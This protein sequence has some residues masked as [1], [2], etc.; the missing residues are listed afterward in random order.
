MAVLCLHCYMWAFSSCCRRGLLF[1]LQCAASHCGVFSCGAPALG[2]Q[3]LAVVT[4]GLSSCGTWALEG[5]LSSCGAQAQLP[6]D[7]LDPF[8]DQGLNLSPA[9]AGGFLTTREVPMKS[10]EQSLWQVLYF[11][12]L[13]CIHLLER[14]HIDLVNS[15]QAIVM[16]LLTSFCSSR[17]RKTIP[18]LHQIVPRVLK[19]S[20]NIS[21]NIW[22]CF[23]FP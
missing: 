7:A 15:L 17:K 11:L 23:S 19:V 13:Q 6:H 21:S 2:L 18:Q 3:A 4:R 1:Q 10:F 16:V 12:L 22:N 20:S 9:L 8:L 14:R 5:R